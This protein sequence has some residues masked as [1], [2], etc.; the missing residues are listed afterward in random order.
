MLLSWKMLAGATQ[1]QQR[2][3]KKEVSK[4]AVIAVAR[5]LEKEGR[6]SQDGSGRAVYIS[7]C[8]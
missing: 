2:C 1:A 4:E 6:I 7:V 5:Q 3:I 8:R